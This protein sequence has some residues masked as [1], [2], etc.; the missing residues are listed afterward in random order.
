MGWDHWRTSYILG[1]AQ[2]WLGSV[3]SMYIKNLFTR[4]LMRSQKS[5]PSKLWNVNM[6][7]CMVLS[8]KLEIWISLFLSQNN[9]Q[10]F[11][12]TP[13]YDLAI[14]SLCVCVCFCML[15]QTA[16]NFCI[17]LLYLGVYLCLKR[18]LRGLDN[19]VFVCK[20]HLYNFWFKNTN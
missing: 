4:G 16:A 1:K 18:I 7:K 3:H 20:L 2:K 17:D 8:C 12:I 14:T 6:T 13:I 5:K 15:I 9:F 10:S 19:F 11:C